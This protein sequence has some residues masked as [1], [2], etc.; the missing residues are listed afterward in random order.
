MHSSCSV[1][2][3]GGGGV[4][5]GGYLPRGCTPAP[6]PCGQN[7]WHTLVKTLPFRNEVAKVMFLHLSVCLS[8]GGRGLPQCMLGYYPP[9][10]AVTLPPTRHPP[11]PAPPL[12]SRSPP[13]AGTPPSRRLLLRTVR[14]L[15]EC[16][17]VINF[18][19][20]P[21]KFQDEGIP[22]NPSYCQSVC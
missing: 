22:Q 20:S 2:L 7:S 1:C 13:G 12:G 9:P 10:R 15:L 14:I 17:L 8:T 4:S 21:P 5:P 16:I 6:P 3:A 11:G 19:P 18:S